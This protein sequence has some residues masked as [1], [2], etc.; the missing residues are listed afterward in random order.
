MDP[1]LFQDVYAYNEWAQR[2]LWTCLAQL[3]DE[4]FTRDLGYSHGSLREQWLH[5]TGTVAW[6]CGFLDTGQIHFL[7]P[8]DYQTRPAVYAVWDTT[9]QRMRAYLATVSEVDLLREVRPDFWDAGEKP[10]R[11]WQA[12]IQVANHCTDHRA[13]ILAG[14]QRL[15]APTMGQDYLDFL[16]A[17]Q[18]DTAQ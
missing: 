9:A 2:R 10:I 1:M 4:Q 8:D 11:M 7:D 15:G 3:S 5:L 6:W 16:F 13:Q 14:L 17:R 18:G 12:L